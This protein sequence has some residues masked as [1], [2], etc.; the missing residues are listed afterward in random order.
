M[1]RPVRS[2]GQVV[3]IMCALA[4]PSAGRAEAPRG[5][6][7]MD[8]GY[9]RKATGDLDGAAAAFEQAKAA[10]FDA[11]RAD[12]ELSYLDL[13][14]QR[15]AAA[16]A[17]L[18]SAARG[19]DPLLAAQARGE[20]DALPHALRRDVYAE[21]YGWA[22]TAGAERESNIVPMLRLRALYQPLAAVPL[23]GY[24]FAQATRDLLS[25]DAGGV[26]QIY[27]DTRAI[28]GAGLQLRIFG[29]RAALFAQAGPAFAL[30]DDGRDDVL[31]DFRAGAAGNAESRGC[32]PAP[33]SGTSLRVSPCGDVYGAAVYF[34]RFD[35]DAI[36]LA[37]GRAGATWLVTGSVAWT[38]LFETQAS[39][40]RIGH[41]YDN[42]VEAG[43]GHRWRL[44]RPLRVDLLAGVSSGV[45]LRGRAVEPVPTDRTY[46]E[47]RLLAA[48]YSE[49]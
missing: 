19:R 35:H 33:R 24:V 3:C 1:E 42:F 13:S 27:A 8:E 4:L 29:S 47:V 17:R 5:G 38:L 41:P 36:A 9:A 44:L 2:C 12:L 43:F 22:R 34:S 14:A 23:D 11:Q 18:E 25:G 37:R 32:S 49:F 46:L 30:V 45:V 20:L 7:L 26:P 10:G 15:V 6:D 28:A 21:A 40:D 39:V 31:L 48:T 16:R